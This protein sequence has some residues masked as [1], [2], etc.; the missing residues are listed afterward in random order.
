MQTPGSKGTKTAESAETKKKGRKQRK[1]EAKHLARLEQQLE[2]ELEEEAATAPPAELMFVPV[3]EITFGKRFRQKYDVDDLTESIKEKGVVQPITLDKDWNLQAGGRRLTAAKK[4]GL[5]VIPALVRDFVDE[6]DSREIELLENVQREDLTWQERTRLTK[7]IDVLYTKKYGVRSAGVGQGWSGRKT[8]ELLSRSHGSIQRTLALAEGMELIPDI[9][10]CKTENEAFK[11]LKGI[12]E[13][14]LV[15]QIR[16]SQDVAL[17]AH[18]PVSDEEFKESLSSIDDESEKLRLTQERFRASRVSAA[19][20]NFRIG[21]ALKELKE[22]ADLYTTQ[23]SA[24][25]F[26]ECDPPFGISLQEQK[27]RTNKEA[28]SALDKYEEVPEQEYEAFLSQL[29]PL[30][31][32]VANKNCWLIFWY[33]PSWTVQ[34]LAA[35]EA[36]S[37]QVDHIP[38]VWV[39]GEEES[40]GTGQTGSPERYLARATEFF[41]VCRKGAPILVKE[42][43][44]NVFSYKPTPPSKKYHPTQKPLP[45]Y[46]ELLKTFA[47]PGSVLCSPFLGSGS[48]LRAAY[49]EGML[50][51]G[52]D[53]NGKNK[54]RFLIAVED[55]L[56]TQMQEMMKEE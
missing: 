34:V 28:P 49:L 48:A 26:I 46:Q 52:W 44:T 13:S 38:A 47:Y 20:T 2:K 53:L 45:L 1:D 22:L 23:E 9:A 10:L 25:R 11:M 6:I 15:K 40:E 14:I 29:C 18:T 16:K 8:A 12:E 55:D 31:Y 43:R 33:G 3:G 39:K 51:L 21:N 32:A 7:E 56:E 5:E 54:D 41:F 30:L 4:A 50:G 27:K 36:A 42:G 24:I 17:A 37:W 35:L 19:N